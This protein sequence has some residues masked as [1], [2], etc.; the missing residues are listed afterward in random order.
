MNEE[1]Q[2]ITIQTRK[3]GPFTCE[4]CGKTDKSVLFFIGDPFPYLCRDCE[5]IVVKVI[6]GYLN[7]LSNQTF[8]AVADVIVSHR[9]R[10]EQNELEP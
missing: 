10:R 3:I 4:L 8:Q 9:M 6:K 1:E 7:F 5:P 2:V